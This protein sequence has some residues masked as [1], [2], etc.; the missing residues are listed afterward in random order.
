MADFGVAEGQRDRAVAYSVDVNVTLLCP[1]IA[2][3]T[4][5]INTLTCY[6]E[7][8]SGNTVMFYRLIAN[9]ALSYCELT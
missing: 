5:Y 7:A 8:P 2:F 1:G 4:K 3:C 6:I 9:T